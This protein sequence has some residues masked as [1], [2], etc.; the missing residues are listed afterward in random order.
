MSQPALAPRNPNYAQ[1]VRDS[2]DRQGAMHLIGASI[3]HLEPGV[4]EIVLPYR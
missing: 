3:A 4:C 1:R 2:F